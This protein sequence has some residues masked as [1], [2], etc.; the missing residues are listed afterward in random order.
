[1]EHLKRYWNAFKDV[2][3]I[4]SF[5][6]NFVLVVLLLA[7]S[8]PTVQTVFALK[9]GMVEP[10][11]DDLDEAFVGLGEATIDTSISMEGQPARIK[12]TLPLSQPLGID[13]QLPIEQPT[14]VVLTAPVPL[15]LPAQFRLPGGGGVI[16]GSVSL[17]LPAGL[18]LPIQLN[19]TVP[20]SQT[21]PVH[22]DVPV[23]QQVP[24]TMT[25]P[26]RIQLGEAGLDPAVEELRAVFRPLREQID[27]LPDGIMFR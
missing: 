6:V 1:M 16:N 5:V 4:F 18:R 25:V 3:I 2:A 10:L 9:T 15:D 21:V 20:V 13:F 26:V 17:A 11:L 12:F 22:M 8:L 24:I 23:D 7:A 19:M 14:V 27:G